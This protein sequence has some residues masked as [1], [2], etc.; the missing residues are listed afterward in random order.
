MM[1]ESRLSLSD[2]QSYSKREKNSLKL[3]AQTRSDG[4]TE[5][6]DINTNLHSIGNSSDQFSTKS[7]VMSVSGPVHAKNV[8]L[9]DTQQLQF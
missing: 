6:T 3:N 4:L 9:D 1:T 2:V 5:L 7:R 8:S